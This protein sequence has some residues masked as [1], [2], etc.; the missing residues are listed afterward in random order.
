MLAVLWPLRNRFRRPT[1]L[2]WTTVAAYSGGRFV[3][4]F[5]RS[6]TTGFAFGLNVAQVTSLALLAVALIGLWW[7]RRSR[8]ERRRTGP[9]YPGPDAPARFAGRARAA[10][11]PVARSE[12]VRPGATPRNRPATPKNCA[13]RPGSCRRPHREGPDL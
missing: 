13:R 4:F 3:M 10:S 7:A 9:P 11:R 1:T 12:A 5:W 2:L 6:D 8:P